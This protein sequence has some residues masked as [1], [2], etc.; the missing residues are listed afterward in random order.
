MTPAIHVRRS[1]ILALL[2]AVPCTKAELARQIP[3]STRNLH[4]DL[5]WITATF[6]GRVVFGRQGRAKTWRFTGTPPTVLATPIAALDEDQ[7]AALIAARGLL[8]IPDGT[9][10]ATEGRTTAYTGTLAQA[11]Q[12]LINDAGLGAEAD[13]IAPDDLCISRFGVASEH[14]ATFPALLAALRAGR[15]VRTSYTNNDSDTHD[16]HARPVRL[17]MINGE[18]HCFAWAVGSDGQGRI[19]QYRLSRLEAVVQTD[20]D[21][22]GCPASGLRDQVD[23]LLRDAFR[24]TGSHHASARTR[25][26]LAVSPRAWPHIAG[27]RWGAPVPAPDQSNLAPGWRRI[28]FV[29]TGLAECRHWVLAFGAEVRA[30]HPAALVDWIREQAQTIIRGL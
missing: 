27:R 18:W 9:S 25:V 15:A 4:N 28:A 16:L 29:T 14:P 13:A 2:G 17:A 24:A 7:I 1:R 6:P 26:E 19:R 11:L 3:G 23:T 20:T 22:P 5:A 12:R 10:P 30:E 8:R 21:P